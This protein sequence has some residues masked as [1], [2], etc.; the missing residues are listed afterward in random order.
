MPEAERSK[1]PAA[2]ALSALEQC[3]WDIRGKV[4]GVPTYDLFGGRIQPRI[5]M[6]GNINRSTDP[7]T[8]DGFADMAAR[9][10]AAGFDAVKLAPFDEMP[11][12]LSNAG[13][14]EEFTV[15]GIA[16]AEAVRRKIGPKVDLLVDVHS[17]LDLKRGLD[18]ARRMEHLNL[19]WIEEVTPAVPVV[20]L[21]TINRDAK[22]PTAGG[23]TILGVKGFYPYIKGEAVDV[24][25]P[26]V[27]FCG[28]MLE[29]KKIAAMAE[30]AGLLTAPHGPAS[31]VG[32]VAAAQVCATMPNFRILE[33]SYGEVPWRAELIDP[34]ERIVDS[35]L[36]LTDA[37]GFGITLNE[38]TAAQ[39][40]GRHD[41]TTHPPPRQA[42][43]VQ[44]SDRLSLRRPPLSNGPDLLRSL[45]LHGHAIDRETHRASQ[46]FANGEPVI[47]QLR[48]LQDNRRVDVDDI[49]SRFGR[50]FTRMS[51]KLQ[52]PR[53]LPLLIGVGEV[54]ADIAQCR[55]AQDGIG[56]GMRQHIGIGVT[57]QA[58]LARNRSHRQEM[59]GRPATIRWTS[60]PSPLR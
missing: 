39:V 22:M 60:Q 14:T 2:V 5:R 11:R 13:V 54:H 30:G 45:E 3:L 49:A 42:L 15:R 59:R 19:F 9:A 6:Y 18:L 34:P 21:A 24:V 43:L 12:D 8:P 58:E 32:N 27:K 1:L 57:V 20:N 26:D 10:V 23:E 40:R 16:C 31:P 50:Q 35:A 48:L 17:H 52:T 7:R 44:Q 51:Q 36:P 56:N 33:F 38:K 55:R 28:G 53:S 46:A 29:L 37:P 25:M 47:L 41:P 4:F